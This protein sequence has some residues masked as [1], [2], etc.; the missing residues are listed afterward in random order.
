MY[1]EQVREESAVTP[2]HRLPQRILHQK[3]PNSTYVLKKGGDHS[4]LDVP[5]RQQ[6]TRSESSKKESSYVLRQGIPQTGV[7]AGHDHS[8]RLHRQSKRRRKVPASQAKNVYPSFTMGSTTRE[9]IGALESNGDTSNFD[10]NHVQTAKAIRDQLKAAD[11]NFSVEKM[12]A[13]T[14]S[15]SAEK[16]L[17]DAEK[18]LAELSSLREEAEIAAAAMAYEDPAGEEEY[19]DDDD[20]YDDENYDGE[21]SQ[22]WSPHP[23]SVPGRPPV[24]PASPYNHNQHDYKH[25]SD[26]T[27][28]TLENGATQ[29][30]NNNASQRLVQDYIKLPLCESETSNTG[31]LHDTTLQQG[32]KVSGGYT[33]GHHAPSSAGG[34]FEPSGETSE[35]KHSDISGNAGKKPGSVPG[36]KNV[37]GKHPWEKVRGR[38]ANDDKNFVGHPNDASQAHPGDMINQNPS[39][40]IVEQPEDFSGTSLQGSREKAPTSDLPPGMAYPHNDSRDRK[41]TNF[42]RGN[43]GDVV[44]TA[45]REYAIP[46]ATEEGE[47]RSPQQLGVNDTINGRQRYPLSGEYLERPYVSSQNAH[48]ETH[49]ENFHADDNDYE[50]RH[51]DRDK[52]G[53]SNGALSSD[54]MEAGAKD[55]MTSENSFSSSPE[56][57]M[58][59]RGLDH[60]NSFMGGTPDLERAPGFPL[61]SMSPSIPLQTDSANS[62]P[63]DR[64]SGY[65]PGNSG[66]NLS[67]P[68]QVKV[69][70]RSFGSSEVPHLPTLGDERY[71]IN[72]SVPYPSGPQ[73]EAVHY[74]THRMKG[75]Y[76]PSEYYIINTFA[77]V[78]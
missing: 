37:I 18:Y 60:I 32:D 14:S 74:S 67:P 39:R 16:D 76:D 8:R 43:D 34:V 4:F 2:D 11:P 25:S 5:Q 28:G 44:R 3:D 20:Y 22:D 24:T 62:S 35:V 59:Q 78:W 53:N 33:D 61:R 21:Q 6:G 72:P 1:R 47:T 46:G 49:D 58:K 69:N 7:P 55:H 71:V 23:A 64:T 12:A 19:Y 52:P 68:S 13:D 73:Q 57:A 26:P 30:P 70:I 41:P 42:Q 15:G 75:G 9:I 38:L 50:E 10:N 45:N 17:Q 29:K 77:I 48:G 36:F 65:S 51:T 56:R 66:F 27:H 54:G 40:A 63:R 31:E